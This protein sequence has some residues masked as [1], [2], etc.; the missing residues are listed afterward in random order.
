MLFALVGGPRSD[1]V[2]VKLDQGPP[3]VIVA[4]VEAAPPTRTVRLLGVTRAVDEADL[5][6][7]IAGR[8]VERAVDVGDVVAA[9][10]IL[11]RLDPEGW[12]IGVEQA[13]AAVEDVRSRAAQLAA[14]RARFQALRAS[15]SVSVAELERLE[16]EERAT[17]ANLERA[18]AGWE[19]A[20]RQQR[21]SVLRAPREGLVAAVFAEDRE[22]LPAGAPVLRLVGRGVE[23][24]LEAPETAWGSMRV[25]DLARVELPG[26]RCTA[27][28]AIDR[29][30]NAALGVGRLFPVHVAVSAD[31]A[32]DPAPGMAARVD[33]EVKVPASLRVPVRSV[34]D[35]TGSGAFVFAVS[36]GVVRRVNV[37]PLYF[38]GDRVA[39]HADLTPGDEVVTG[40]LVGLSD[41]ARVEVRR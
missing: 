24:V 12:R 23:V 7:T 26:L 37:Q 30:G 3:P 35:P 33:V 18:K 13:A 39:I 9:G 4:Q 2:G 6:L 29:L 21:E 14:D 40:G 1:A 8:L 15:D 11:A 36:D 41:G 16:A 20:Q 19:E 32:C 10:Q 31:A 38:S 5:S 22:T 28:G 34:V 17:L 27:Q 25:G